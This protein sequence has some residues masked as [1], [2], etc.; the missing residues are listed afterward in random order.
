VSTSS[1]Q[2]TNQP[3]TQPTNQPASNPIKRTQITNLGLRALAPLPL[4][5]LDV[6]SCLLIDPY[7][8]GRADPGCPASVAHLTRLRR[9]AAHSQGDGDDG[10]CLTAPALRALSRLRLLTE[11]SVGTGVFKQGAAGA[12][13]LEV[14]DAY[15]E[16]LHVEGMVVDAQQVDRALQD[17]DAAWRRR[18]AQ[19]ART[20]KDLAA[21]CGWLPA[22]QLRRLCI[23][24]PRQ[25]A[26]EGDAA[27]EAVSVL[28]NLE[29]LQL[30]L[31]TPPCSASLSHL[32]A[33]TQLT[34]RCG[35]EGTVPRPLVQDDHSAWVWGPD[36]LPAGLKSLHF[37]N[38][39]MWTLAAADWLGRCTA[40]T[41]LV[42]DGSWL[43][44]ILWDGPQHLRQLTR[45]RSLTLSLETPLHFHLE[46]SHSLTFQHCDLVAAAAALTQLTALTVR[47]HWRQPSLRGTWDL[48]L[49]PHTYDGAELLPPPG[50][51][52]SLLS[53]LTSLESLEL[54]PGLGAALLDQLRALTVLRA[55]T[56]LVVKADTAQQNSNGDADMIL[57]L[58]AFSALRRLAVCGVPAPTPAHRGAALQFSGAGLEALAHHGALQSLTLCH[59]RGVGARALRAVGRLGASLVRLDLAGCTTVDDGTVAHLRDLHRLTCAI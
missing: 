11:L 4:E 43:V 50:V 59:C 54:G 44:A 23:R 17:A 7:P 45:L 12:R 35:R 28:T 40:L 27:L 42:A 39:Y 32:T 37:E 56:S 51:D 30:D 16:P 26:P 2:P 1:G 31:L 25:L 38:Y 48:G 3:P 6:S 13:G 21:L 8:R 55:L 57:C 34:L 33:L 22:A 18:C 41:R 58:G 15:G 36:P 19:A 24:L 9:L 53:A 5:D 46:P 14:W 47:V 10:G 29:Q 20:G 52:L 49:V